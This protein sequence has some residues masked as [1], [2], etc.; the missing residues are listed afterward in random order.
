MALFGACAVAVACAANPTPACTS[1]GDCPDGR[2]CVE[3]TCRAMEPPPDAGRDAGPPPEAD[4]GR[5]AGPTTAPLRP[6]PR[7][8]F[9]GASTGS[10]HGSVVIPEPALTPLFAWDPSDGASRYEIEITSECT[11]PGFASCAFASP[12]VQESVTETRFRAPVLAVGTTPP[13]GRRY[14]WR[15]RACA[16]ECSPW[17]AVRYLDVGRQANDF[18]GDGYADVLAGAYLDDGAAAD[19]GRAYWWSGSATGPATVHPMT[20]P[21][22]EVNARFGLEVAALGDVDGD[23]FADAAVAAYFADA[24]ATDTGEVY[25]YLGSAT[26]LPAAPSQTIAPPTVEAGAQLG[27]SLAPAGDVDGDGFADLVVGAHGEDAGGSNYGRAYVFRGGPGG[28]VVPG[29]RL[30]S[31]SRQTNQQFGFPVRGAGDVDG[32]GY[33]D[34]LVGESLWDGAQID[35]GRVHLFAGGPSGVS[36][37]PAV[38]FVDAT[39]GEGARFGWAVAGVGDLDGDHL[40]DIVI[41]ARYRDGTGGAL[42]FLG[43]TPAAVPDAVLAAPGAQADAEFGFSVGSPGDVDGDGDTDVVIGAR[44][45]DRSETNEGRAYVYYGV[46]GGL[47]GAPDVTLDGTPREAGAQFGYSV[48][49]AGDVDGDGFRDVV[50]GAQAQ[51]AGAVNGGGVFFFR[52]TAAGVD[53]A[54]IL[55]G[56]TRGDGRLG[57]SVAAILPY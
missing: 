11:T 6:V 22:A 36:D 25:V 57:I 17:S 30:D 56:T 8:P 49:G 4:A 54:G 1:D 7:W 43:G 53:P 26:G 45:F 46:E 42:L 2:A 32:D 33:A 28:L 55:L 18:D 3:G 13:V 52:G 37:R 20:P 47:A 34:L 24:G 9:N 48:A 27:R 31:P 51:D 14:Y 23:G 15:V 39:P 40:G 12:V 16:G 21:R 10:V 29:A 5:D 50:V 35:Q 44:I 19:Q 38:S 41:G